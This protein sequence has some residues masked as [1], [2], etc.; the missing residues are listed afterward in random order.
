MIFKTNRVNKLIVEPYGG[1]GNRL[2]TISSLYRIS[3]I[4]SAEFELNWVP[5]PDV[6]EASLDAYFEI[7]FSVIQ[8]T[9]IS[10]EPGYIPKLW[11]GSRS[12]I[13]IVDLEEQ[14]NST[15]RIGAQQFHH[16]IWMEQDLQ[17]FGP[18]VQLSLTSEIAE[19]LRS[20]VIPK[21][22]IRSLLSFAVAPPIFDLGIHL[23][24]ALPD[25]YRQG[26]HSVW[27]DFEMAHLL[28]RLDLVMEDVRPNSCF[29]ASPSPHLVE[30]VVSHLQRKGV[31]AYTA[32]TF[33]LD[34]VRDRDLAAYLEFY[35]LTKC[36]SIFRRSSTTYSATAALCSASTEYILSND[37]SV[38]KRTPMVI[39]G[40]AL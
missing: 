12:Y 18:E 23:R 39:S 7:P 27:P 4:I 37:Y 22:R 21:E 13:P 34:A 33:K 14:A 24:V 20:I 19:S 9:V 16:C 11:N 26:V 8:K 3:R 35:C 29:I 38:G 28:S 25:D 6:I 32:H 36:T 30:V 15:M 1:I 10:L 31:S 40:H 17:S 2:L 5:M